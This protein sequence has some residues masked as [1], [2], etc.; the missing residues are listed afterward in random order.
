MKG[1]TLPAKMFK[2]PTCRDQCYL[3]LPNTEGIFEKYKNLGSYDKQN[4]YLQGLITV[5]G[6]RKVDKNEEENGE[7]KSITQRYKFKYT[8]TANG[9]PLMLCRDVFTGIF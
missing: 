3:A 7:K 2:V 1:V 5:T 8:V 9:A 6:E 4:L